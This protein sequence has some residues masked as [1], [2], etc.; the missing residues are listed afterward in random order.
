MKLSKELIDFMY[1]I[2]GEEKD[3]VK[4]IKLPTL[5]EFHEH[6]HKVRP[7]R[8]EGDITEGSMSEHADNDVAT[9]EYRIFISQPNEIHLYVACKDGKV[10]EEPTVS[11][12]KNDYGETIPL[13]LVARLEKEY[14]KAQDEVVF[15]GWKVYKDTEL[16][17]S[18]IDV[19]GEGFKFLK[20]GSYT[21]NLTIEQALSIGLYY[22][23]KRYERRRIFE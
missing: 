10:L 7:Y 9:Y 22:K 8:L 11:N 6:L 21:N 16:S 1:P 12:I 14:Q 4:V 15:F 3:G 23:L 2:W 18:V 5:S 13:E 19:N 17:T 20:E